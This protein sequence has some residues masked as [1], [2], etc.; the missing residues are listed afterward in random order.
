MSLRQA[1]FA[2]IASRRV[3]NQ[4]LD[5]GRPETESQSAGTTSSGTMLRLNMSGSSPANVVAEAIRIERKREPA[6]VAKPCASE[7]PA[8]RRSLRVCRGK[9]RDAAIAQRVTVMP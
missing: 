9:Y 5:L 1:D 4:D 2:K 8:A 7:S 6:A 3:S